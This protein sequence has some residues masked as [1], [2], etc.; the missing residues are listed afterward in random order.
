MRVPEAVIFDMDSR[1]WELR[2]AGLNYDQ[3]SKALECSKSRAWNGVQR[4]LDRLN[5]KFAE[6]NRDVFRIEIERLDAMLSQIW[7][8][9]MARDV[10]REDG[11]GT[12]RVPPSMDAVDRVLKIMDRK[13]KM[14]GLD[15]QA[16]Q[17]SVSGNRS[18]ITVG[19]AQKELSE[20]T[21]REEA[22]RFMRLLVESGVMEPAVMAQIKEHTGLDIMDAEIVSESHAPIGDPDA[23]GDPFFSGM[24]DD[25]D[26]SNGED[27][28]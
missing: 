16:I 20:I 25:P 11:N 3:I 23:D 10:P 24:P 6:D 4:S 22:E 17:L 5:T 2:K 27:L 18:E 13:A 19:A 26:D 15:T 8:Q 14:M 7:P 12:V 28:V 1:C 9:T 21:P